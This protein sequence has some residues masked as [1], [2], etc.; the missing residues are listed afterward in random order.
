MMVSQDGSGP[1]EGTEMGRPELASYRYKVSYGQT[2]D[3]KMG[4]ELYHLGLE[5]CCRTAGNTQTSNITVLSPSPSLSSS[6]SS[7]PHDVWFEVEDN[8]SQARLLMIQEEKSAQVP[9]GA[10]SVTI[11]QWNFFLFCGSNQD[12]QPLHSAVETVEVITQ[13]YLHSHS[14]PAWSPLRGYSGQWVPAELPFIIK[15]H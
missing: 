2:P 1:V 15:Y 10:I 5:L 4:Q 8:N 6:S 14:R 13:R 7:S 12:H 9:S 11:W 3:V